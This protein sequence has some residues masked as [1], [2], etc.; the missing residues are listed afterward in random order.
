MDENQIRAASTIIVKAFPALRENA[1]TNAILEARESVL[2]RFGG[3]FRVDRIA[4]L[5]AADFNEFLRIK[6]NRHW[7]L[8]RS[9]GVLTQDM[10]SLRRAIGVL[11]DE[12]RPL[13]ERYDEACGAVTGMG[14]AIA[15]AILLVAYPTRCGVWNATSE[16]G[17]RRLGVFPVFPR[18]ATE[19][20]KYVTVNDVLI[21]ISK[22]SG[23]HLWDI[24]TFL[25]RHEEFGTKRRVWG[26]YVGKAAAG[27]F[28]AA[29]ANKVWGADDPR[30]F[31][32]ILEGDR[33]VFVHDVASNLSPPPRGF[34][35]VGTAVEFACTAKTIVYA[36]VTRA[37]YHSTEKVWSDDT[38]PARFNIK[39]IDTEDDSV[40][41]VERFPSELVDAV[42][43]SATS[44]G[45]PRLA[46]I[47]D[48][49][50]WLV[51]DEDAVEDADDVDESPDP[52]ALTTAFATA[53][54]EA[55]I[56]FGADHDHVARTFMTSLMTK[57][58]VILTGLSGSGK[59]QIAIKLG[60]WFGHDQWRLIPVRPDW[61]GPEHLLGYE[62]GLRKAGADGRRPWA[63]PQAL[64][65]MLEAA[66]TP[67]RPFLLVLDE[68]NL[69]HV[70]RYFADVLSGME[71]RTDVLPN[72][73]QAQDGGWYV[74]PLRP[75]IPLPRNLFIVGTV[76]VDETTYLFSPKVLDR[77]NTIEFRVSTEA[78]PADLQ[79]VKR[80]KACAVA[81]P[82]LTR[83]VLAVALDEQGT[84]GALPALASDVA[85]LRQLHAVLS[86]LGAEFGHR[87]FY[88][89][90]RLMG[91][92]AAVGVQS[93]AER[94][95]VVV[96][97][98]LLPRIHGARRKI[99][100]VL[101]SL[102]AFA[103][104]LRTVRGAFRFEDKAT[105][106]LPRSYRKLDRM[107]RA[108]QANQ[109]ASFADG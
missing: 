56:S 4:Q 52:A 6:N 59:T 97:Q 80:P 17:L 15:S 23:L 20:Q 32:D 49:G 7:P 79:S 13:A 44:T 8:H 69:A 72:L 108:L 62:D 101:L 61:T 84:F 85:Q 103:L 1:E 99:E 74:D 78:L 82:A 25:W 51:I 58:F 54:R 3:V 22:E 42:R 89:S 50:P 48:F 104:D 91:L 93:E 27:N 16:G 71:S 81:A 109:F 102:G 35:R 73:A 41:A 34:P 5:S 66:R 83:G 63:V 87:T 55:N 21:R 38:Y 46:T 65:F 24:D 19:G 100:P 107:M 106:R 77:A 53:L 70:E 36:E 31:V 57:P 105:A 96:L 2:A 18:G 11:L 12:R 47:P 68:M 92:L 60:E 37:P 40:F 98:K 88:E 39:E 10:P 9:S 45:R 86:E 29:R 30:K 94:L 26:I 90:V 95:D 14:R 28:A 75:R 43:T 33:V 76:N 67:T 64:E